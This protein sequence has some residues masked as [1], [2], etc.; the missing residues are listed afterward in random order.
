MMKPIQRLESGTCKSIQASLVFPT[1]TSIILELVNRSL[2]AKPTSRID[3]HVHLSP[4][5]QV[6]CQDDAAGNA[7]DS[8][9]HIA[10]SSLQYLSFLGI[11]DIQV[12]CR[13]HIQKVTLKE[14][15]HYVGIQANLCN[16]ST[17][18]MTSFTL[19]RLTKLLHVIINPCR[20]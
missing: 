10:A 15:Q 17:R 5:W 18:A 11:L 14:L 12:G 1:L 20:V 9:E 16:L 7:I 4:E 2:H 3:I 6:T 13:K 8:L 19:A